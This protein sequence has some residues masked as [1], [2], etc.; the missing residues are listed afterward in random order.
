[1][2]EHQKIHTGEK[3][4]TCPQ[5][6]AHK[7]TLIIH[8]RLHTGEKPFECSDCGKTFH[9][10][11]HLVVHRRV[12]TGEKP[13]QIHSGEKPYRCSECG[14]SFG[15]SRKLATSRIGTKYSCTSNVSMSRPMGP[16]YDFIDT[17][18]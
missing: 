11:P 3:P 14:Q 12:H 13:Y 7:G 2:K 18:T 15:Y 17:I 10:R 5:P 4:F 6:F 9:Q 1:M 16:P 8:R